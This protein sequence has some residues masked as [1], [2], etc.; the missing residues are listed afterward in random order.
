M[1]REVQTVEPLAEYLGVTVDASRG[2]RDTDG[3]AADA[4]AAARAAAAGA[5]N[6]ETPAVLVAWE[7]CRMPLIRRR[8]VG[9]PGRCWS[10]D[11]YDSVDR[12][13]VDAAGR[14]VALPSTREGFSAGPIAFRYAMCE[15][16]KGED[17]PAI[18]DCVAPHSP[19]VSVPSALPY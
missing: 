8:F 11:D 10:D 6:C 3:V 5:A 7:H 1:R 17:L 4:V 2:Q 19:S 18:L 15:K 14:V 16:K 9:A 12:F 13:R